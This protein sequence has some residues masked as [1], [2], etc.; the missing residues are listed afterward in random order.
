MPTKTV[1][2]DE[3]VRAVLQRSETRGNMLILPAETLER[4]LYIRVDKVLRALGGRW[5]RGCQAHVFN[6][7][8]D[9]I[10]ADALA[11]DHVVD[12]KR[13]A[14]Q[15]FTPASLADRMARLAQIRRGDHVLEPS[16]GKGVLILSALASGAKFIT[17][18]EQDEALAKELI[19]IVPKHGSGVWLGDFMAWEPKAAA[20]IDVVL[21]NPPFSGNQD[22]RHVM[23]A[24]DFLRPGGR[25]VAIMSP[26][27]TFANDAPSRALRE[28]I[29][30]P[31]GIR[32]GPETGIELGG[33]VVIDDATVELL[34]A[35][36]F[37][38]AG[39]N[40]ASVLVTIKKGAMQ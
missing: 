39:T 20:P 27:F 10:I 13:S 34:P 4:Y 22:I 40:V 36:T 32:L 33:S 8:A 38:L 1:A 37:K 19:A 25:L 28:L 3:E 17:A 9:R 23:R 6:G 29:G 16:A 7:S 14:E 5:D 26:H 21:M 18:V 30:F 15:F 12:R 24:L 2:I 11:G 35:G 31:D